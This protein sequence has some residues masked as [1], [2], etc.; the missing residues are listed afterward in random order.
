MAPVPLPVKHW[1]VFTEQAVAWTLR[2]QKAQ[3]L[4][5]ISKSAFTWMWQKWEGGQG[6]LSH[7]R[8]VPRKARME[9][10]HVLQTLVPV[11]AEPDDC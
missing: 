1:E 5:S 3:G 8:K 6:G 9:T 2:C 7:G 10:T 4:S 11:L